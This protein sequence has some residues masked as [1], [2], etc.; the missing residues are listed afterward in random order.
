MT[1][2]CVLILAHIQ[3]YWWIMIAEQKRGGKQSNDFGGSTITCGFRIRH[4]LEDVLNIITADALNNI[5]S[6][7]QNK[8]LMVLHGS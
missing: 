4:H 8:L 3:S 1:E 6:S 5:L 2:K 7:V